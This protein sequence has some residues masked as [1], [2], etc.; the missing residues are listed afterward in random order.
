MHVTPLS[1]WGTNDGSR[2]N[3]EVTARVEV[4]AREVCRATHGGRSR[5]R[6]RFLFGP[7]GQPTRQERSRVKKEG[8]KR[9]KGDP[10]QK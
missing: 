8:R 1:N 9:K 10:L 4:P 2:L 5:K 7:G 3:P 6:G